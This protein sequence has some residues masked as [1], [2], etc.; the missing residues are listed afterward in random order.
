MS[1]SCS[2][3]HTLGWPVLSDWVTERRT[4]TDRVCTS[5]TRAE[6]RFVPAF[7]AS[8]FILGLKIII[9]IAINSSC[10]VL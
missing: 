10:L 7:F 3:G 5:C 8:L 9:S 1:P 6:R 2:L 4:A